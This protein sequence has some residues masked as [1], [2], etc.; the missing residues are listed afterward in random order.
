[1]QCG[2][3]EIRSIRPHDRFHFWV[4][5]DPIEQLWIEEWAIQ[6][7]GEYG[8]EVNGL[9]CVVGKLDAQRVRP[10]DL[11]AANL[12]DRMFHGT[13]LCQRGDGQCFVAGLQPVPVGS[14]FCLVQFSPCFD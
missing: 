1:M 3:I 14:Q 5:R 6:F 8:F 13:S 9:F 7:A 10:D 2:G 12:I 4:D 11:N